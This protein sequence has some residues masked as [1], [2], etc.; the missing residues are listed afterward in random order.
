MRSSVILAYD[1]DW[2]AVFGHRDLLRTAL[3]NTLWIAAV[4][5]VLATAF[6]LL[7]AL[8]RTSRVAPLRWVATIYINVVRGIPL[9]VLIF[10]VYFGVSIWLGIKFTNFQAGVIS[11]TVF[12]TAFMAEIF[13]T[14]LTA[15]PAGQR[16]AA[17]SLGISRPRAF[18]S[19]ILPQAVRVAVPAG[20]NDFVGMVKDTSLVGVIGI[21]ELYRTGQK[22]VSDTFL[23]FEVWTGIAIIYICIVFVIDLVVRLIERRLRPG[24][25]PVACSHG[26]AGRRS[27][28]SCGASIP[29]RPS[30]RSRSQATQQ[31]SEGVHVRNT[32][33]RR[34]A[35]GL[36]LV[37]ALAAAAGWVGA[38]VPVSAAS[39]PDRATSAE[40]SGSVLDE[41]RERGELRVGM[42]LQF[43][44]EMYL[45][46]NNEPAG[47][48]VE[49]LELLATDLEVELT[50]ENQEFDA[51]VPGLLAGQWD[52]ISV[53]LVPR[54]P[55]L[56]Q[57]YFTDSYVPYE[58]VLVAAADSDRQ[59]TI[60]AYNVADTTITAL[61]GSTAA[62][63][64]TTQFPEATLAEF[65]QQDAAF[66]EVASGRADAIVVESYLA[67]R[68]IQANPDELAIVGLDS[69]LQIEYGAYA[70]P[71]GDDLF[72]HYL[73]NWL[74]YYK[75]NGTLDRI[76]DEVFGSDP[77]VA[78]WARG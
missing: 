3:K 10:Y 31:P 18:V 38:S 73:N 49:L 55:R 72:L 56:L 32:N 57:M 76:Y 22:L 24:S 43:E 25:R 28:T 65:P 78:I 12:H 19:I 42:S 11:L 37:T 77:N 53:G 5:M 30:R 26:D 36:G 13:R 34:R 71:L 48:D 59:P 1:F 14:G 47:Y 51:L 60:E 62:E 27:T 2:S 63:Q 44:P 52:M 7:L 46:E 15:V 21:F 29:Q 68:F 66:L 70:I 33:K 40:P 74:Q 41:I 58:Q 9:L 67:E 8:L 64:V 35:A 4:S 69:P 61:Q 50:I 75:N 17:L 54:P 45:D 23:P 20:G 6:G 16:E 39:A